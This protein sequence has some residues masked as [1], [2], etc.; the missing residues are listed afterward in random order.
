METGVSSL[1]F[2]TLARADIFDY[3]EVFYNRGEYTRIEGDQNIK[4]LDTNLKLF[5]PKAYKYS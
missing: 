1:V 3:I 4:K 2:D 5:A